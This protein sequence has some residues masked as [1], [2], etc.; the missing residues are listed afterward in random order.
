M[1]SIAHF[2]VGASQVVAA[3][4]WSLTRL[5]RER[6]QMVSRGC[7]AGLSDMNTCH[8][9]CS[10]HCQSK[11]RS[12]VLFGS[13]ILSQHVYAPFSF[14]WLMPYLTRSLYSLWVASAIA[15]F[16]LLTDDLSPIQA[17]NA[18]LPGV[19]FDAFVPWTYSSVNRTSLCPS[20]T[21]LGSLA[22]LAGACA[23]IGGLL[24]SWLGLNSTLDVAVWALSSFPS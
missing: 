12:A 11:H 9:C 19:S 6:G 23:A 18:L 3:R 15:A 10:N 8:P 17:R 21:S 2:E 5:F 22:Y 20:W 14:Y 7:S 24:T 16:R 4:S 13:C 1:S